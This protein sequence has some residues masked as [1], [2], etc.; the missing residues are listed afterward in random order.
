MKKEGKIKL[1]VFIP[2][3]E[4]GGTEKYVSLLCNNIS[5]DKFDVTLVVLNNAH[6][7]YV[8]NT[9]NINLVDLGVKRVSGS[10]WRIKKI[11]RQEAPDIILTTAN[12]LNLLFA[13]FRHILAKKIPVIARESSI[14]SI[15]TRRA[16]MPMLYNWL[17]KRFYHRFDAILCQSVYMQQDLIKNFNMLPDKTR[18]IHNPVQEVP[19]N[20]Q[21]PAA[22]HPGK[23]KFITVARLSAEKGI[24]RLILAVAGLSLPYQYYIIGEGNERAALQKQVEELQLQDKIFLSGEKIK[25]WLHMEDADLFLS[26]S[27]YEGFPNAV[28]EAGALGI[29]VIAFDAPGGTREIITDGESG[30]LVK[31]ND[32]T[33]FTT[34]IEKALQVGFNRAGIIAATKKRFSIAANLQA[35]EE[36]LLCAGKK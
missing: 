8:I 25:P 7:F 29:P 3:L 13:M 33:A 31:D 5:T 1:L 24:D 34:G 28:L 12:H 2:T 22:A 21:L 26:G 27:Y 16:K 4:C 10:F 15:N 23:Y 9:T 19:L 36:L 20:I 32:I 30:L 18:V 6:P 14:V 11:I 17:L 35:V